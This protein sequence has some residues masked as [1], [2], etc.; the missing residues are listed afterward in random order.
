MYL[1]YPYC[2]TQISESPYVPTFKQ[3][4]MLVVKDG[5]SLLCNCVGMDPNVTSKRFNFLLDIALIQKISN[6]DYAQSHI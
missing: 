1:T 5:R 6:I 4:E 2:V 3:V